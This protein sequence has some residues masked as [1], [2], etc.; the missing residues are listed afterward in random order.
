VTKIALA[1]ISTAFESGCAWLATGALPSKL[2][3]NALATERASGEPAAARKRSLRATSSTWLCT[4]RNST[5]CC[6]PQ[7]P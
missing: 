2:S 6:R 4:R 1:S 5:I 3:E 7:A